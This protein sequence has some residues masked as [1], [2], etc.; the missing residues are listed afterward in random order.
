MK[1]V[2]QKV[3]IK[4]FKDREFRCRKLDDGHY[5]QLLKERKCMEE[6]KTFIER[7]LNGITCLGYGWS[8]VKIK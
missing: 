1:E 2:P 4:D 8:K 7:I 3:G 6:S 5:Q